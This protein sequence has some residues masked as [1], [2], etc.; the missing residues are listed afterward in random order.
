LTEAVLHGNISLSK[1]VRLQNNQ[2]SLINLAGSF[3]VRGHPSFVQDSLNNFIGGA[4][5]RW[6]SSILPPE[7]VLNLGESSDTSGEQQIKLA[8][9]D[10]Y[11]KVVSDDAKDFMLLTTDDAYNLSSTL[12]TSSGTVT[13]DWK[14]IIS[15]SLVTISFE[16]LPSSLSLCS[17]FEEFQA[18]WNRIVFNAD[19]WERVKPVTHTDNSIYVIKAFKV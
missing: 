1:V 5:H 4:S 12:K 11:W 15:S 17:S 7:M 18:A 3:S 6:K 14:G 16:D 13:S 2:L 19:L 8:Q 9:L 10:R